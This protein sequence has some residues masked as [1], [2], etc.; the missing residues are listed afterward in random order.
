[1]TMEE[2]RHEHLSPTEHALLSELAGLAPLGVLSLDEQ[3]RV[4]LHL[5]SGCERCR[6]ELHQGASALDV[7]ALAT[8]KLTP[9]PRAREA[10][11]AAVAPAASRR[12]PERREAPRRPRSFVAPLA[13]P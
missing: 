7:L 4:A 8:P 1:M 3:Q 12:A 2:R 9:S 6:E 10:L 13:A 11:L 5:D